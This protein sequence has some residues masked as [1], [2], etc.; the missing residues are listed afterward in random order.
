MNSKRVIISDTLSNEMMLP[1]ITEGLD[2]HVE[3]FDEGAFC[4]L[5]GLAHCVGCFTENDLLY[6]KVKKIH[7]KANRLYKNEVALD[8]NT[9]LIVVSSNNPYSPYTLYSTTQ[10]LEGYAR[11]GAIKVWREYAKV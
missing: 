9:L 6:Q 3:R 7:N 4:Y 5:V 11:T 8:N 2:I 1:C 10:T